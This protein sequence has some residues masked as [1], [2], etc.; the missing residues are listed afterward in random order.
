MTSI[1][2]EILEK[3]QHESTRDSKHAWVS[4][5][6]GTPHLR[7]G[8][9]NGILKQIAKT[10]LKLELTDKEVISLIDDLFL[11]K[12]FEEKVTASYILICSKKIRLQ[13]QTVQVEK[14]L[15][16]LSG[17]AEIDSLC[18]NAFTEKDFLIDWTSWKKMLKEFNKSPNISK[19]RASLV[20]LKTPLL[21]SPDQRFSDLTIENIKNLQLEKDV[22]ITKAISWLLRCL[23]KH[24][25]KEV[26]EYLKKNR[27]LLPKIAVRETIRKLQTGKK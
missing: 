20:L 10:F 13:I 26:E 5:Y 22:L 23:I 1:H 24:H 27:N 11:S 4:K 16:N 2:K 25:K 18:Q 12:S 8:V 6:L 14:W 7:Y 3:I 21:N 9:K 15:D 19:R 17:W